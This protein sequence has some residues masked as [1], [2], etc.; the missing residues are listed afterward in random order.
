MS[1]RSTILHQVL[2][3]KNSKKT[4]GSIPGKRGGSECVTREKRN[5]K[6]TNA[7]NQIVDSD[8][9]N[10]LDQTDNDPISDS[11]HTSTDLNK[12]SLL[13]KQLADLQKQIDR[14]NANQ[15][16]MEKVIMTICGPDCLVNDANLVK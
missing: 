9:T 8:Q 6:T 15:E 1:Y 3:G 5:K 11:S 4:L 12:I 14:L 16:V 13:E 2:V 10:Q 7:N